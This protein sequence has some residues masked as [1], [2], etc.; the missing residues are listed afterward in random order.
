MNPALQHQLRTLDRAILDLADERLRLLA[1]LGADEPARAAALED[2][3]RRHA[4]PF[5]AEG[6]RELFAVLDRHAREARP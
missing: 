5:P 1:E 4:G 6:V 2:L 3:L